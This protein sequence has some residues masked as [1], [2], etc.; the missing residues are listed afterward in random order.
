MPFYSNS[1][2]S[3]SAFTSNVI[4]QKDVKKFYREKY[5]ITSYMYNYTN[6]VFSTYDALNNHFEI[7]LSLTPHKWV[8]YNYISVFAHP[9]RKKKESFQPN[10]FVFA[11]LTFLCFLLYLLRQPARRGRHHNESRIRFNYS[12]SIVSNSKQFRI[13]ETRSTF[14][15]YLFVYPH[16]VLCPTFIKQK[17]SI[18]ISNR[19]KNK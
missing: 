18:N 7:R 3:L 9:H 19:R 16:N 17:S 14:L 6:T 15:V 4:L 8:F 12:S 5:E 13:Y 11:R 1:Y 2:P 10:S